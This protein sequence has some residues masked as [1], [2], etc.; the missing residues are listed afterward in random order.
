MREFFVVVACYTL[1]LYSA[2]G[3]A[4][5]AKVGGCGCLSDGESCARLVFARNGVWF[6]NL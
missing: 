4:F 6:F 1:F 5:V 3:S 2:T